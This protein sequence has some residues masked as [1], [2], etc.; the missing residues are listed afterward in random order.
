MTY[1][2]LASTYRLKLESIF[3]RVIGNWYDLYYFIVDA[4]LRLESIFYIVIG[5]D[6]TYIILASTRR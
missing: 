4:P 6:M 2:I 5:T 3:Y 1:I